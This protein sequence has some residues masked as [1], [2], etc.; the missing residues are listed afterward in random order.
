M[1]QDNRGVIYF[2]GVCGLCNR[3]VRFVLR[4]D[5]RHVF[6]YAPLQGASFHNLV[7]ES[8]IPPRSDS[9][10]VVWYTGEGREQI[11]VRGQAVLVILRQLPSYRWLAALLGILPLPWLD[12]LYDRVAAGRYRFFGKSEICR[13]PTEEEERYFL[14]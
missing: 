4:R 12:R 9:L 7:E 14:D 5:R 8:G 6:R 11:F 2:D 3:F 13:K 10:V 1:R